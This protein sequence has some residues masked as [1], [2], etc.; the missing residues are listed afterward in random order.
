M[1]KQR[2]AENT[3]GSTDEKSSD[4]QENPT[5]ASTS[6]KLERRRLIEDLHEEK[7]LREEL[8]AF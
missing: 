2:I 4:I 7:R 5:P 8:S 6:T 3:P 1:R